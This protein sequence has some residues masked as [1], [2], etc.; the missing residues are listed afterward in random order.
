MQPSPAFP[1]TSLMCFSESWNLTF[2]V[3]Y[4]CF[5]R[6]QKIQAVLLGQAFHAY[7]EDSL[8]IILGSHTNSKTK[9]HDF[10]M[11]FHDRNVSISMN[12]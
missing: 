9:F 11:T 2:Y 8:M 7:Q 5:R 3:S 12:F 1:A 6:L 4:E 10:Y